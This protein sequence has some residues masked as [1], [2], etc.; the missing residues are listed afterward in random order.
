MKYV[1]V[2]VI[3]R[4]ISSFKTSFKTGGMNKKN[5]Q[6]KSDFEQVQV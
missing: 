2:N 1:S 4:H 5:K 3:D 6:E